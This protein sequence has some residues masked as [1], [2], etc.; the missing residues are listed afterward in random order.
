MLVGGGLVWWVTRTPSAEDAARAY[1]DALSSGDVATI[2]A[3]RAEKLDDAPERILADAFAGAES[4]VTEAHIDEITAREGSTRVLATAE[5][6]G[7]RRGLHFV[8]EQQN[9]RW[10]LTG[11]YLASVE[12]TP[13]LAG[14]ESP[15]GDSVWIGDALAPAGAPILL[16]PAEYSIEAAPRGLLSGGTSVALGNRGRTSVEIEASVAAEATATAQA[17][18]NAYMDECTEPASAIPANCGLRVPWAADLATLTSIVFRIENRP[19]L[20]VSPDG[21]TFAAADGVVVATATGTTRDGDV[22]SFSYRAD[23]WALRGT[24]AF[25]GNEMVLA[26]G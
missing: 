5:I 16:L 6:A 9:G 25:R 8:M 2:D 21:R 7:E 26:V 23:D 10:A 17:Q 1:L 4:F 14:T 18:L 19:T 20:A 12:V 15:A 3:M 22:E 13:T 24:V 11:D